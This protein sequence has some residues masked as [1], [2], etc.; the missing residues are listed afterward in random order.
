MQKDAIWS[1]VDK[2]DRWLQMLFISLWCI[3]TEKD[4]MAIICC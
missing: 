1:R 2:A 3:T 4:L